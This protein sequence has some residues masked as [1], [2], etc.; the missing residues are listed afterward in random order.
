VDVTV[1]CDENNVIFL[2]I[3]FIQGQFNNKWM[4]FAAAV[5]LSE[6][7]SPFATLA[8]SEGDLQW[9]SSMELLGWENIQSSHCVKTSSGFIPSMKANIREVL[10]NEVV[11]MVKF[12]DIEDMRLKFAEY[13]WLRPTAKLQTEVNRVIKNLGGPH[14]YTGLHLRYFDGPCMTF[15]IELG[16]E[17]YLCQ[18]NPSLLINSVNKLREQHSINSAL[19][20]L[21]LASDGQTPLRDLAFIQAGAITY[22]TLTFPAGSAGEMLVD[23]LVLA[24]S[25]L[26]LGSVSTLADDVVVIRRVLQRIQ[27]SDKFISYLGETTQSINLLENLLTKVKNDR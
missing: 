19:Q 13:V 10:P 11:N 27:G 1:N 24:H 18:R 20:P 12:E 2:N 22:D 16:Y 7:Y 5:A 15:T 3:D 9:A 4:I 21:Y 14:N 23:M 17:P 8:V 6:T 25:A 26:F